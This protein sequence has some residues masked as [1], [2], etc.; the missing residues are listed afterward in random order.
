MT[1]STISITNRDLASIKSSPRPVLISLLLNYVVMGS[2][3]LLM[4]RWLISDSELWGGFV[5]IA[6]MPPAIAVVP[7]SYM[8]GGNM[9]FSLIGTTSLYLAALGLTPGIMI[10]LLGADFFNP[11]RLLLILVQLI[12]I[13]LVVS[14]VFLFTGLAKSIDKWQGTAVSWCYF[15]V[16]FTIIGLNRQVFFQQPDFL[17]KIGTIAIVVNFGLGHAID[18]IARRLHVDRQTSISWVLMGTRKNTGL[19]SVI[20][21]AFLGERA[22]IPHAVYA[23]LAV[24]AILWWGFYFKKQGK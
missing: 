7:F 16:F 24:A 17:F 2:T 15:I 1:L 5:T 8:L 4:A 14:R 11:V 23:M 10:L 22:T 20:A 13:P 18:F 21:L 19:A 9:A 6:A 3:T 12:V